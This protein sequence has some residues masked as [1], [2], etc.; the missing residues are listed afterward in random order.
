MQLNTL[1]PVPLYQQLASRLR[2][3]IA[4][5]ELAEQ[6]KIPSE[7]SLAQ[8]YGIGRPTVRQA[9]DLLV[10][11]GVLQRR[12]GSGTF[13]LPRARRID[14]FSLAGTSAAFSD[15]GQSAEITWL[16]PPRLLVSSKYLPDNFDK[17]P[18][19]S[20]KRLT[21]IEQVP[22]LVEHLYLQADLFR[23]L[24]RN[25]VEGNSLS[26]VVRDTYHL[27]AT[28]AEQEFSI[29]LAGSALAVVLEVNADTPL[30]RVNRTLHFGTYGSAI[31]CDIHCRTDQFRF[32]Q[33]ITTPDLQRKEL[34]P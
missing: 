26:R 18:Y 14:L 8:Q 4:S 1:S 15:S 31:Y 27:E 12:R 16:Q 11:E 24:D 21:R 33:T 19:F 2:D 13:V 5:G 7:T 6:Q 25:L 3:A 30:L 32:S 34:H 22:V 10:R 23:E 20:L 28:S 9:T 29:A 17:P